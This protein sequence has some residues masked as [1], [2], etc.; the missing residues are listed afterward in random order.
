MITV[1]H[2]NNSRS[3]RILW[4]LEELGVPYEIKRY[5]RNP[6]T[7]LAPPELL[8]IHPMGKSPVITEG[9]FTLAESGAII[10]YLVERHGKG[11][12]APAV[13]TPERLRYIYWMH[14]AEGTAMPFLV[15]KLVFNRIER[16]PMPF[17][18]KPIAR[19]IASQTKKGYVDPNIDRIAEYVESELSKGEWFCGKEFTAADIQMSLACE[20]LLKRARTANR[21]H[22]EQFLERSHI[23]P[24]YER[25]LAK[26]GDFGILV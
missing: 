14:F 24:A 9:D 1:H 18:A 25:A 16:A 22:I 23:R 19:S 3:Q 17:F 6:K 8:A 5:Q 13:G 10:E 7:S 26:V 21:P 12:L 4:L 15:M 11:R 2:L 20:A